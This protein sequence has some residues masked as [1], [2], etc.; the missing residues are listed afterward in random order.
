M[1]TR[2]A[3]CFLS[4]LFIAVLPLSATFAQTPAAQ[5]PGN[6]AQRSQKDFTPA[7]REMLAE[8]S[9]LNKEGLE[10]FAQRK[11]DESFALLRRALELW[12]KV[13]GPEDYQVAITLSNIAVLA[14][15]R[16]D[17]VITRQ[18]LQRAIRIYQKLINLQHDAYQYEAKADLVYEAGILLAAVDQYETAL[19]YYQI[20][21]RLYRVVNDAEGAARTQKSIER[22]SAALA[23]AKAQD[24]PATRRPELILQTGHTYAP[25]VAFS[26][27]GRLLATGSHDDTV[28]LWDPSNGHVLRNLYAARSPIVFSRDG[29]FLATGDLRGLITLWDVATG[30]RSELHVIPYEHTATVMAAVLRKMS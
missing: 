27:D 25:E 7:E 14:H 2:P 15:A 5:T 16:G 17:A 10:L 30:E 1:R 20:A 23:A 24:S 29:R 6:S 22:A 8:A 4:L 18:A 26:P 3:L 28:K 12:L 19:D 11:Y 13:L 21:L 9:R